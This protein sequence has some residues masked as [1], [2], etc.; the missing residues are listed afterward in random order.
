[1]MCNICEQLVE[2]NQVSLFALEA[3]VALCLTYY[4]CTMPFLLLGKAVK[5]LL[6]RAEVRLVTTVTIVL[7]LKLLKFYYLAHL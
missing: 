5:P 2:S 3:T 4:L 6:A 1:M 7:S